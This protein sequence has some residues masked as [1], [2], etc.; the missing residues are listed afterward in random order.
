MSKPTSEPIRNTPVPASNEKVG[1]ASA[2]YKDAFWR[3]IRNESS[4][5]IRNALREGVPE[6]ANFNNKI[7]KK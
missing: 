3:S 2:S 5:E 1:R 6:S 7:L 4:Y